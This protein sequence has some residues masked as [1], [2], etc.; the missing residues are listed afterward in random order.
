VKIQINSHESRA[1][2]NQVIGRINFYNHAKGYGFITVTSRKS[3]T[4]G[5]S[6]EQF[7]FH[8]SNFQNRNETPVIGAFVVF[9]LA[10]GIA[11]GKKP[12]AVGIRFATSQ[13]VGSVDAGVNA[14]AAT[15]TEV[16]R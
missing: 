7:F 15:Q 9:V 12:Q 10:P 1:E 4:E 14:L 2:G 8:Y 3:P 6:Q 13:E 5:L 11:E 16:R